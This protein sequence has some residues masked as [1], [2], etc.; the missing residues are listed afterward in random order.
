MTMCYPTDY[1]PLELRAMALALYAMLAKP[2]PTPATV[3]PCGDQQLPVLAG[4]GEPIEE[5]H[6]ER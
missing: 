5:T 1:T 4:A 3:L 6:D 2:S